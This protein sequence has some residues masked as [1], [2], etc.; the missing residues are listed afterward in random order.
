MNNELKFETKG[1]ENGSNS[2]FRLTGKFT[3]TRSH[4]TGGKCRRQFQAAGQ[5]VAYRIAMAGA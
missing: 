4:R 3:H 5:R 2:G 1:I